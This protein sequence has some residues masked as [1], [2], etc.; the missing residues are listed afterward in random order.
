MTG[1]YGLVPAAPGF[2]SAMGSVSP[3][4]SAVDTFFWAPDGSG[5][6]IVASTPGGD[7]SVVWNGQTYT[8]TDNLDGTAAYNDVGLGGPYPTSGTTA[9]DSDAASGG[10][11]IT[12][13][14]S[15][16]SFELTGSPVTFVR[17]R[18]IFAETGVFTL[19]GN[20]IGFG[21]GYRATISVGNFSGITYGY[22][23][24]TFGSIA[25][26]G[27]PP[28]NPPTAI[29][30]TSSGF[31]VQMAAPVPGDVALN[32]QTY[33]LAGSDG[34]YS[35]SAAGKGGPY[36][37]SGT[38][39]ILFT[40]GGSGYVLSAG[41]GSF[42][43]TGNDAGFVF[44]GPEPVTP[45]IAVTMR[46][47]GGPVAPVSYEVGHRLAGAADWSVR[48]LAAVTGTLFL[49]GYTAGQS[50]ELRA[51][52]ASVS[53]AWSDWSAVTTHVVGTSD[54][55][56]RD[57]ATF[58]ATWTGTVWHYAWALEVGP[59]SVEPAGI[60]IRHRL[61]A[62][63]GWDDLDDLHTGLLTVAPWDLSAPPATPGTHT[64]GACAVTAAGTYGTPVLVS[65]SV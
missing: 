35:Y 1:Y 11:G 61:G 16:G 4:G 59:V 48:S 39:D 12:L 15:R 30:W 41:A 46:P 27:S 23:S 25:W 6:S 20:D 55:M 52:A 58:A 19:T 45:A 7:L 42:A 63:L 56:I 21:G 36:P 3:S 50:V 24:G 49:P 51:R 8:L 13:V 38:I 47:G 28:P 62:G 31:S 9:F 43:L 22:Q 26:S 40:P 10:G 2:W 32:G 34:S 18:T 64:F 37:T 54:P 53:G 5:V 29:S 57:V 44:P 60:K 33:T 65:V 14:A 17:N